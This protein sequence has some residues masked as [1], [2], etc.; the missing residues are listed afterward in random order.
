[1]KKSTLEELGG[2]SFLERVM[3]DFYDEVYLH[4]W[5]GLYFKGISQETI[6]KQQVDFMIG[7]LGGP[8][9]LYSGRL[10]VE[11]HKNMLITEELFEVREKLLMNSLRKLKAS[12]ELIER[13]M[14]IDQAFKGGIVK[15]SIADCEKTFVTDEIISYENPGKKV[16][17]L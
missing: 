8:K 5:L 1:M 13:W 17:N 9:D 12:E 4:P 14:K 15:K 2:K 16:A 7:V 3:K 10:P 11:A 6:E